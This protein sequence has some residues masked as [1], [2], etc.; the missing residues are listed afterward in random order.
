MPLFERAGEWSIHMRRGGTRHGAIASVLRSRHTR[1][2]EAHAAVFG[3]TSSAQDEEANYA[4]EY[5]RIDF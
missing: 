5:E 4:L 2:R 3:I 1:D